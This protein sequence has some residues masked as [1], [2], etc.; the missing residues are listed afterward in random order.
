[1]ASRRRSAIRRPTPSNKELVIDTV[2]GAPAKLVNIHELIKEFDDLFEV[3]CYTNKGR[4][5]NTVMCDSKPATEDPTPVSKN[6]KAGKK[7]IKKVS[8]KPA[9][10]SAKKTKK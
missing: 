4:V 8:K 9:K 6:I 10:K 3:T 7:P 5:T 1:M 2:N